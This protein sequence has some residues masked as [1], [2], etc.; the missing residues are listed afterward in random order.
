MLSQETLKQTPLH[1][2]H[3]HL[4]AKMVPFAGWEMPVQYEGILVEYESTRRQCSLFDTSHMGEFLI[5]ADD[6]E[7]GLNRIVTQRL[8]DIP[9]KTCRYGMALNDAGGILDDLIVYRIAPEEW[10]IVVNGATTD[11]MAEHF[12]RHLSPRSKFRDVS[13]SLGK[14]DIQGPLSRE[15]LKTIVKGRWGGSGGVEALD[16]YAFDFFEMLSEKVIVSRTGY[17][18]EL[19]YEIYFPWEKTPELWREILKNNKVKP[20][21]LGARDVLRLEMGYSLYGHELDETISP[22]EAGL[23]KFVDLEKDFIGRE[24]L[25]RQK[26]EGVQRTLVGFASESRKSPRS[27]Q[28]LYTLSGERIGV[29]TSGTFSP[30]LQRGIGMGFVSTQGLR[31]EDQLFVGDEKS[32]MPVRLMP[33]PFYKGG[34][35]KS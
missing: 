8:F 14:L 10:M 4:G 6:K 7:S 5:T 31:K 21:G 20:A 9:L 32:K 28:V 25:L 33:R 19:G 30:G 35:L 18:G 17:T 1:E 11:K 27:Q 24:A 3:L 13:H 34:S 12:A 26:D 2:E 16:Y 15:I 23:K 29:V 22:L